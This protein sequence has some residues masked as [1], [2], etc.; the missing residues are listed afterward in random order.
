MKICFKCN[1]PKDRDEFYD[2]PAMADGKLGKC[3][4]CCKSDVTKNRK[5]KIQKYRE[6]D[7]NRSD[8]PHRV[9]ARAEYQKTETGKAAL[10]RGKKA[11]A[12]RNPR[13]RAAEILFRNRQRYDDSLKPK[14]CE[15]CGLIK[16]HGHHENYDK[17]LEVVWL[18]PKHHSQRHKEMRALGIEP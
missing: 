5:L 10:Q 14:P 1:K 17:P 16:V 9:K 3:K 6:F 13:K 2:H 11:W 18:C 4:E 12:A 7:R 15:R 8:L